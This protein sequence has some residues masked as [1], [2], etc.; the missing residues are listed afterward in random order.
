MKITRID[1]YIEIWTT[2][3][4]L[5]TTRLIRWT[6]IDW[7]FSL[8][9]KNDRSFRR[10][11]EPLRFDISSPTEFLWLKSDMSQRWIQHWDHRW[12]AWE[13]SRCATDV[14]MKVNKWQRN[15]KVMATSHEERHRQKVWLD[16]SQV[17]RSWTNHRRK[18]NKV[19]RKYWPLEMTNSLRH[20]ERIRSKSDGRWC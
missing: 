2:S 8:W 15:R 20:Q 5:R 16:H 17:K 4:H 10:P 6:K 9:H 3:F 12:L 13:R 11:R 1:K 7:W 19:N 18:V 14:H